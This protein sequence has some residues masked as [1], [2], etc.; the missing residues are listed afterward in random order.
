MADIANDT[1]TVM[2]F[3]LRL[4]R[5]AFMAYVRS[6]LESAFGSDLDAEIKSLFKKEWVEVELNARPA[7]NAG[8]VERAPSDALDHLGVNQ[9]SN[10]TERYWELLCPSPNPQSE[11]SKKIRNNLLALCRD[12][13][14]VRNPISH[15]PEEP[16]ALRDTL[17]YVDSAA[18]I[19]TVLG[20]PD[21]EELRSVWDGLIAEQASTTAAPLAILDTLPSRE[22]IANDFVGRT[23]ELTDLWR[24]LGD[25]SRQIWALVG[26]GGKGKTTIAYEFAIQA[27]NTLSDYK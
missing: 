4:F 12:L 18:R 23:A 21:A 17:R 9:C 2:F 16:L 13:N 11:A 27:R 20:I 10:L 8:F 7:Q 22:L 15:S 26:D 1:D 14:G 24:W 5:N 25:D 6:R 19:L 3:A